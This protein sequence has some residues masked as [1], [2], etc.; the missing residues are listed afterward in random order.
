MAES[1]G[2]LVVAARSARLLAEAAAREGAAAIALDC[3]GDGDTRRAAL[4]WESIAGDGG[5]RIDGARLT[6]AL[7]RAARA[8]G[9][10]GWVA[11][12]D[13]ENEPALLERGAALLP[14]IG[15][16]PAAV[17]RVRDPGR[18]F[19]ALDALGL[20]HP[21]TR[22]DAPPAEPRGWLRKLA[23]G[24]GGW[25]IRPAGDGM[26][27]R[28]DGAYFQREV[29]G[30]PMSAL[31]IAGA[32]GARLVAINRL[33][34]R[35]LG[36]HHPH[37]W[38]GALGPIAW[39]A[40]RQARL[41]A[42][43]DALVREFALRGLASLDFVQG[44]DGRPW[45]LEINPRPPASMAL[46]SELPLLAAH[47]AACRGGALPVLPP[48][49]PAVRGSEIVFAREALVLTEAQASALAAAG[50]CHDL[51]AAGTRFAA[52]DPVCS[53]S[54]RADTADAVLAALAARRQALRDALATAASV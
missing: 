18:F 48:L 44:D 22:F 17:R 13:F 21:E 31:F 9:V 27:D 30:L 52:G 40:E 42:M 47:V 25:H 29:A 45:L 34:V 33:I 16:P 28:A 4:H 36:A 3:Y 2:T 38:R 54:T 53:L 12:S 41:Q 1:V 7:A 23:Q 50:D 6:D 8:P 14:L 15:T 35:P 49:D 26:H 46:Y 10:T 5:H 11:G 24:S 20:P 43:L 32:D 19:A 39:P 51:P 37:V